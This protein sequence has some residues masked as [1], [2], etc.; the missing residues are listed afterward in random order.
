MLNYLLSI[1]VLIENVQ[2]LDRA[3][4]FAERCNEPDVWSLLA[5]AQLEQNMVKEAIDSFIKADDPSVY[6]EVVAIARKEG[7]GWRSSS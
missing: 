4:E 2:N 5:K 1:Q 7:I 6:T 3:Y